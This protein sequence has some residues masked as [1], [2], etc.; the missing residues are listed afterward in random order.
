MNSLQI[1]IT[2]KVLVVKQEVF[3]CRDVVQR[4]FHATGGFGCLPHLV[5]CAV[6]GVFLHDGDRCR[7]DGFD[8]ERLATDEEIK[9]AT[10]LRTKVAG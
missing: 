4:V 8:F 5:G 3:P 10:E 2:D 7:L 1:D 6:M 9:E